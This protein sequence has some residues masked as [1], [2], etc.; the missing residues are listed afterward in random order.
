MK[1]T[2]CSEEPLRMGGGGKEEESVTCWWG[3]EKSKV[4]REG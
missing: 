3:G 1:K 4:E 2:L